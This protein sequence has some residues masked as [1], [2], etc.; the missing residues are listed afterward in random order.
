VLGVRTRHIGKVVSVRLF[1][2]PSLL[3]MGT[4]C[5]ADV[6][7][8]FNINMLP[9]EDILL[10][11]NQPWGRTLGLSAEFTTDD[12]CDTCSASSSFFTLTSEGLLTFD[13]YQGGT[14]VG[15]LECLVPSCD[16]NPLGGSATYD[17]IT[18]VFTSSV[19]DNANVAYDF[20]SNGTYYVN[21]DGN[22]EELGTFTVT[23]VPE[24]SLLLLVITVVPAALLKKSR[25]RLCTSRSLSAEGC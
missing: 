16:L 12:S 11:Y 9:T 20:Y 8:V 22:V 25:Q 2:I 6:V 13:I 24:P 7:D 19:A 21:E 1:L 3:I 23:P 4:I 5:R 18:G 15:E 10:A 17:R 14:P